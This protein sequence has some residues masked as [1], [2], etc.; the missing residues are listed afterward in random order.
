MNKPMNQ[1]TDFSLHFIY[2]LCFSFQTKRMK[3]ELLA[4]IFNSI[5]LISFPFF[6]LLMSILTTFLT[7]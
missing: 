6:V 7:S 5:C 2:S 3:V 4:V 1:L